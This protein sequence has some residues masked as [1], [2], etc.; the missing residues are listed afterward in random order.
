MCNSYQINIQKEE[1]LNTE[2][3]KES[4]EKIIESL[5]LAKKISNDKCLMFCSN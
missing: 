5:F 1:T 3:A 4:M 2:N